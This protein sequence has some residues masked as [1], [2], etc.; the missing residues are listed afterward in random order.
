MVGPSVMPPAAMIGT[1]TA[2]RTSGSRTMEATSRGFL[3]PPPSPPSTTRPSTPAS[4]ALR[5]PLSV[6]TTW[7]TVSPAAFS[8]A[9]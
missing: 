4:I 1:S 5:A 6:G 8:W 7:K 3:K 2:A 9:V